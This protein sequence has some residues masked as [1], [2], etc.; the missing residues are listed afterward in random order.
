MFSVRLIDIRAYSVAGSD[1]IGVDDS[2]TRSF[3]SSADESDTLLTTIVGRES[4]RCVTSDRT[5]IGPGIFRRICSG[6][7]CDGSD[8][9]VISR[10]VEGIILFAPVSA[11]FDGNRAQTGEVE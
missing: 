11:D 6:S 1:I 9:F 5:F 2:G 3:Y 4:Q 7:G 8:R 10:D